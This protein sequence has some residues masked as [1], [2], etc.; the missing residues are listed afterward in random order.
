MSMIDYIIGI[1]VFS[2]VCVIVVKLINRHKKGAPTGC[3]CGCREC[4]VGKT[5]N[6]K[7]K[8]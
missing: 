4:P 1:G 5:C 2:L 6:T 7:R 8:V 3:G